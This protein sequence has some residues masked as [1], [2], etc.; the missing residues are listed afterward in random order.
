MNTD[1]H[2][3]AQTL[4]LSVPSVKSVVVQFR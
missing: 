2:T 4:R 1:K 3:S